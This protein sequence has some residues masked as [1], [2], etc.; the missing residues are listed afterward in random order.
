ME[1][2]L[3]N[4][5]SN[6][7]SCCLCSYTSA[8]EIP[9]LNCDTRFVVPD[10]FLSRPGKSR[11]SGVTWLTKP[12]RG[13]VL[14]VMPHSTRDPRYSSRQQSQL[15]LLLRSPSLLVYFPVRKA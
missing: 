13:Q 7:S 14:T 3:A 5:M 4:G 8:R 11:K 15:H 1:S 10:N 9:S 2:N 12:I 6:I